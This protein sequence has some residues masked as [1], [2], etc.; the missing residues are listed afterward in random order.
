M[1]IAIEIFFLDTNVFLHCKWLDQLPWKDLT[2]HD[3]VRLVVALNVVQEIDKWK[4]TAGRQGDRARQASQLFNLIRNTPERRVIVR[5]AGPKTSIE[6]APLPFPKSTD[7]PD[8]DWSRADD[9]IIAEAQRF[10]SNLEPGTVSLLTNDTIPGILAEAH[11]VHTTQVPEDWLLPAE[12]DPREKQIS[13]LKAQLAELKKS[14][15]SV[16]IQFPESVEGGLARSRHQNISPLLP[17]KSKPSW[18]M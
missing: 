2:S 7:F 6:I 15:A 4:T 14:H 10:G 17:I 3:P 1:A 18:V 9:R 8:F 13:A 12:P 5:G 11:G 16:E